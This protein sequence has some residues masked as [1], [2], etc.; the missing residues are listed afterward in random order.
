MA[1]S[2]LVSRGFLWLL[3]I[4]V[5]GLFLASACQKSKP[6]TWVIGAEREAQILDWAAPYVPDAPISDGFFVRGV[7]VRSNEITFVLGEGAEGGPDHQLIMTCSSPD[8]PVGFNTPVVPEGGA[9]AAIKFLRDSLAQKASPERLRGIMTQRDLSSSSGAAT[10][11]S[12]GILFLSLAG[13]WFSRRWVYLPFFVLSAFAVVL[14]HGLAM[15]FV[16]TP[17]LSE[18]YLS[19]LL[20]ALLRVLLHIAL[21]IG[22]LAALEAIP[23]TRRRP[24]PTPAQGWERLD[25]WAP[26]VLLSLS[27]LVRFV[28]GRVNILADGATLQSRV[29][30]ESSVWFGGLGTLVRFL[31]PAPMDAEVWPVVYV[32]SAIAALLPVCV[33]AFTRAAGLHRGVG[34]IAALSLI[35]WPVLSVL[36][37]SDFQQGAILSLVWLSFALLARAR[38]A[39]DPSCGAAGLSLLAYLTW[40]RPESFLFLIPAAALFGREGRG[41][42]SDLRFFTAGLVLFLSATIRLMAYRIFSTGSEVGSLLPSKLLD[43]AAYFGDYL[44]AAMP[45]SLVLG[46]LAFLPFALASHVARVALL[47]AALGLVPAMIDVTGPFEHIRYGAHALPWIAV[48]AGIGLVGTWE[49]IRQWRPSAPIIGARTTLAAT[50]ALGA[51][52]LLPIATNLEYL[53]RSYHTTYGDTLLRE[54]LDH[55][56]EGCRVVFPWYDHETV[57]PSIQ[58][59]TKYRLVLEEVDRQQGLRRSVISTHDYLKDD[60]GNDG[61]LCTYWFR[62]WECGDEAPFDHS[63]RLDLL[64]GCDEMSARLRMSSVW[65]QAVSAPSNRFVTRPYD[66]SPSSDKL[67]RYGLFR[68]EGSKE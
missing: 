13:C 11:L 47:G 37:T 50:S 40:T 20:P 49:A 23:K 42:L 4:G 5:T 60:A 52:L 36:F 1:P 44:P 55:V 22:L 65:S 56:P 30:Q 46:L 29:F 41:L 58:P 68:I 43:A 35:G 48:A 10:G 8:E 26:P 33:Y 16:G 24:R 18:A 3:S 15:P 25:P 54:A 6:A 53:D 62:S 34:W 32:L 19:A 27:I 64:T 63:D 2:K 21:A 14:V 9:A 31:L 12:Y 39:R 7:G 28:L 45:P 51:L 17:S 59:M 67:F 61:A 57:D 66:W 38:A